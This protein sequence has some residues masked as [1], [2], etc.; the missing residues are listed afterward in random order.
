MFHKTD[1]VLQILYLVIRYPHQ[2]VQRP[3]LTSHI[4]FTGY[5]CFPVRFTHPN[6][7]HFDVTPWLFKPGLSCITSQVIIQLIYFAKFP[8]ANCGHG[9][10]FCTGDTQ[11]ST[12][13]SQFW[14]TFSDSWFPLE[15]GQ[16]VGVVVSYSVAVMTVLPSAVAF[17]QVC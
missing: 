16:A 13:P 9:N 6:M 14:A 3:F 8:G 1:W 12:V 2:M 10:I 7:E 15:A 17:I 4:L 5:K 11:E